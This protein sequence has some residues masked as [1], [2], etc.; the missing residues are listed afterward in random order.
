MVRI[1]ENWVRARRAGVDERELLHSK[2]SQTTLASS[3]ST[4]ERLETIHPNEEGERHG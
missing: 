2:G 1:C 3:L 4:Q